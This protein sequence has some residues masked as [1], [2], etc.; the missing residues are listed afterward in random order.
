MLFDSKEIFRAQASRGINIKTGTM[1]QRSV[2]V[3]H[4]LTPLMIL[5]FFR[6]SYIS[7]ALTIK[8]LDSN[9]KKTKYNKFSLK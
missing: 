9:N 4:S 8:C 1:K 2:A 5:T 3:L 7:D 6:A